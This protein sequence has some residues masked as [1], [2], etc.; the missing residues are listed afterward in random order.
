MT[1]VPQLDVARGVAV[2]L[3]LGRHMQLPSEQAAS[4]VRAAAALWYQVG[5]IAIDLFF[6]LSGFLIA[7]LLFTEYQ[8]HGSL[9][10]GRFLIRRGFKIYPAF[11]VFLVASVLFSTYESPLTRDLVQRVLAEALYVQN[12]LPPLWGPTWSLAV[13]EHFY[14]LLAVVL[15]VLVRRGRSQ[16]NP[17]GGLVYLIVG[18]AVVALILR[19]ATPPTHP[20]SYR[21]HFF[22]TH[23]RLDSIAWGVLL[24]YL[25]H[26]RREQLLAFL[27]RRRWMIAVASIALIA[28][29]FIWPLEQSRF[30]NTLGLTFLDW[31]FA[32]L[33]ILSLSHSPSLRVPLGAPLLRGVAA[34]GFYSY[35]IYLWHMPVISWLM[36]HL[37][38]RGVFDFSNATLAFTLDLAVYTIGSI[39]L[40]IVMARIVEGPALRLRDRLFASRS[41]TLVAGGPVPRSEGLWRTPVT[42]SAA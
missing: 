7:G 24:S 14:L 25:Y 30:I 9:R 15:F 19:I 4:A 3:V 28:P 40:G 12:Y 20:Y 39:A 38:R 2:F 17:F 23:L 41:G 11:Y 21:K 31:G 27:E 34:I 35:S 8:K 1:R 5:W 18:L 16:D 37:R 26:F 42:V 22:P 36:P 32:G 33:L 13:E 29:P 6:V 10:I